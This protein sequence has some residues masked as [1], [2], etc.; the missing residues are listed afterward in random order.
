MVFGVDVGIAVGIV[1]KGGLCCVVCCFPNSRQGRLDSLVPRHASVE[2][3]EACISVR[4]PG[5]DPPAV[6]LLL[7]LLLLLSQKYEGKSCMS[8]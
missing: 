3:W 1:G 5:R 4:R 2:A 8:F 7:L 6:L